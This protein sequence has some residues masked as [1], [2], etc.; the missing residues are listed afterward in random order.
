MLKYFSLY[1]FRRPLEHYLR[2]APPEAVDLIR[3]LLHWDPDK[4]IDLMKAMRHPYVQRYV[5][6][7]ISGA[8]FK[9]L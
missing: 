8:A 3:R 7:R 2:G 9:V 4:R 6:R 1:S 5:Y